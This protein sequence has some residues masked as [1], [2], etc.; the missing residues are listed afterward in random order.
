MDTSE[1]QNILDEVTASGGVRNYETRLKTKTGE[2]IEISLTLSLLK[3]R[4]GSVLGTVGISKDIG[5][6]KAIMRVRT[7]QSEFSRSD[8]F[9]KS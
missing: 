7:G 9:H 2:I 5:R 1:R 6:E 8:P 3:D 4:Q